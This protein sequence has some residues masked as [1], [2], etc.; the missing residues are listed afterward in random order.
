MV[1]WKNLSYNE[2]TWEYESALNEFSQKILN[3][4]HFNRAL[5]KE[6]R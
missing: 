4:K 3:F 2:S 6:S 5:D 1:K